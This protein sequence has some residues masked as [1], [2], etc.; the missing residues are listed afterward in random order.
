[1]VMPYDSIV[2]LFVLSYMYITMGGINWT[3]TDGWFEEGDICN[4]YGVDCQF[5]LLFTLELS[6]NNLAG[7]IPDVIRHLGSLRMFDLSINQGIVG[8]ISSSLTEMT[9]L[10]LLDLS[11]CSL[12]GK[13]AASVEW[14]C[15]FNNF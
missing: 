14:D 1:M 6:Y 10:N 7:T 2:D 4:W 13:C 9:S 11:N 5:E 3:R 8:T 15:Q 12:T